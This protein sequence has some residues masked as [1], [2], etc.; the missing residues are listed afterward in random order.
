MS[1]LLQN[2]IGRQSLQV[3]Q[4]RVEEGA[5]AQTGAQKPFHNV[6]YRAVIREPYPL[7]RAHEAA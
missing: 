7:G 5:V 4:V 2:G 1:H 6:A 3:L